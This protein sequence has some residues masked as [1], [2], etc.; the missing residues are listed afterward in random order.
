LQPRRPSPAIK[1]RLF[2]AVTK[3]SSS[4]IWFLGSLAP[5]TACILLTFSML[6][7]RSGV[8]SGLHEPMLAMVLSNQNCAAFETADSQNRENNWLSVT[9]DWTKGNNLTSSIVP[10]SR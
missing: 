7:S 2:G 5:A 4:M 1:R 6:N 10:F 9:F 8:S 3:A